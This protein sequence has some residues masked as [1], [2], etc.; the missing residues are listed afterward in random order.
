ME[1]VTEDGPDEAR[2]WVVAAQQPREPLRRIRQLEDARHTVI[3]ACARGNVSLSRRVEHFDFLAFLAV[4]P[5]A[6]LLPQRAVLHER[7]EPRRHLEVRV[8]RILREPIVHGLHDVGERVQ[9]D[10]VH[11]A[12]GRAR[13]APDQRTG[14]CVDLIEPETEGRR[15]MRYREQGEGADAI[16]D[17][18]RRVEST[19]HSLAEHGGQE[20][21]E[22]VEQPG[23]GLTQRNQ[24]DQNHVARR[25]EKMDAAKAR[26]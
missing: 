11:R 24:L 25:V 21:F 9:P 14:Q 12:I 19:D 22:I 1:G 16:G 7:G 4:D 2:L 6:A 3:H 13:G 15:V 10:D 20:A 5:A 8:P 18:V 17:E 26:A 23:L